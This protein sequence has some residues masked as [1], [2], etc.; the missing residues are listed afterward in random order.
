MFLVG[1]AVLSLVCWKLLRRGILPAPSLEWKTRISRCLAN[2]RNVKCAGFG[3]LRR[4]IGDDGEFVGFEDA[5]DLHEQPVQEAE[6]AAGHA[7]DRG[8]GLSVGEIGVVEVEAESAPM[9]RQ[10]EGQLVSGQG[11]IVPSLLEA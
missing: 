7:G 3:R 9:S 5:L 8:D 4:I 2:T 1:L 11:A 6:V 10:H